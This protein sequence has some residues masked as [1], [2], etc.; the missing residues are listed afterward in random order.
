M[1]PREDTAISYSIREYNAV[2]HPF[3]HRMNLERAYGLVFWNHQPGDSGRL[4]DA[5]TAHNH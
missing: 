3:Y 5:F 4:F 2:L 1:V